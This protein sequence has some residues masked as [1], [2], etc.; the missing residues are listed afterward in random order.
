MKD[1]MLISSSMGK[2]ESFPLK[3]RNKTGMSTLATIIQHS[4]EVLAS[5]IRQHKEIKGI[6]ISQEFKFSL[7]T[8]DMILYM[9]NPKDFTKNLL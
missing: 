3:V 4:L 9:E 8:D 6:Q 1:P 7:F 2:T 5:G